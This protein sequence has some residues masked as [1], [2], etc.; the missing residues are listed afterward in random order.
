MHL[1]F[2][3]FLS[4]FAHTL[5]IMGFTKGTQ[6]SANIP[7]AFSLIC[8]F[9]NLIIS[10]CLF[11]LIHASHFFLTFHGL[12]YA[13]YLFSTFHGLITYSVIERELNNCTA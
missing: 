8:T 7:I 1:A 6:S 10:V 13:S 11:R 9:L 12:I 5:V 4:L 3:A 2:F